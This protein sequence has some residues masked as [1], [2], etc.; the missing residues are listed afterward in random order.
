[1]KVPVTN[2][3]FATSK[4]CRKMYLLLSTKIDNLTICDNYRARV[5][6]GTMPRKM[7]SAYHHSV[8]I[9]TT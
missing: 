8:Y 1:M 9:L 2:V 7:A 4:Q 6:A 3:H 5:K